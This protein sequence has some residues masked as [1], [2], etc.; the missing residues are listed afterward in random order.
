LGC[1]WSKEMPLV[2]RTV[3]PIRMC[4]AVS[5][6][7]L[8]AIPA[9]RAGVVEHYAIE[10]DIRPET[11]SISAETNM[12]VVAPKDGLRE[13]VM[14]FCKELAIQPVPADAG[15]RAD[16][17]TD[18][19][20]PNR[21]IDHAA[22]LV[23]RFDP[24]L[25]AGERRIVKL[26][27]AGRIPEHSWGVNIIR[28][29]WVELGLYSGWFPYPQ[30]PTA[31]SYSVKVRI[32]PRFHVTG[33]GDVSGGDGTYVLK[34][35][36]D[37][38]DI[39]V[40]A[41]PDL[42]TR[43]LGGGDARIRIDS[44]G[45]KTVEAETIARTADEIRQ[46]LT[47]LFGNPEPGAGS[48]LSLVVTAQR[49]RGGGY[50]RSPSFVVMTYSPGDMQKEG[51][52]KSLAH[53]IAH[54]WWHGAPVDTWEDW[55]NESFAEYT[56]LLETGRRFGEARYLSWIEKYREGTRDAPPIW[57]IERG[58][59]AAYKTLYWKGAVLLHDLRQAIGAAK[60]AEFCRAALTRRPESTIAWLDL[61][62]SMT[63]DKVRSE[64]EQR[65]K[66]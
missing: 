64:F 19:P 39:V 43:V 17:R 12:T 8:L 16:F 58:H 7:I 48:G 11:S 47:G 9:L 66:S 35:D 59:E 2:T 42:E 63:T 55:R 28:P 41:S 45:V 26:V 13:L 23:I 1:H 57:G 52:Q 24:A 15:W 32:D 51:F 50:A 20:A 14:T 30:D 44:A 56:A 36:R 33:F 3:S 49:Q 61:L 65:L 34:M 25:K 46:D 54:I 62:G 31:F 10:L 38:S 22:P 6:Y 27:Y 21:Y 5:A 37:V 4:L 40:I 53:E 29:D 60:F 18:D